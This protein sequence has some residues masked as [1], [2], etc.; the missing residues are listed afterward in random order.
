MQ[1]VGLDYHT[2]TS[3]VFVTD[4]KDGEIFKG[5]VHTVELGKVLESFDGAEVL[6]EAGYGWPR[7]V[8]QLD[9][10]SVELKMCHPEANR[11]IATDRRKSDGRDARNLAVYLR[12]D[13]YKEAYMPDDEIRDERQLIRDRMNVA[14][15]ITR[16]KNRIH[17][18]LAYAGIPKA[19]PRIFARKNRHYFDTIELPARTREVVNM[20]LEALDLCREHRRRLENLIIEMNRKDPRARLLRTIPGVGDLTARVLLAEIGEISRFK[21]ADSLACY[22]GL[23]PQQRQS[24]NSMRT[25]GVTKEGSA[26]VRQI[27][28][29]A[30]WIAIRRDPAL[31]EFFETVK[32]RKNS[33]TAICAVA[34]KLVTF[35]WYILKK[36][37]PYRA[38]KPETKDKP[39]VARGTEAADDL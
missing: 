2:E 30:A 12:T 14:R 5:N 15:E 21:N 27:L 1:Y 9:G 36:E 24:G 31:R 37:V 11:R 25:K 22:T 33:Q 26:N 29:Q 16:H 10:V 39:D 7:L 18:T 8:K 35:A 17:S 20:S 38:Q 13:S 34:R 32:G 19:S 28:V 23:V 3:Y 4:E 6:F